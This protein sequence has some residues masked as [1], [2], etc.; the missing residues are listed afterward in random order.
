MRFKSHVK[1]FQAK[2]WVLGILHRGSDKGLSQTASSIMATCEDNFLLFCFFA[3]KIEKKKKFLHLC[4]AVKI[5]CV[6]N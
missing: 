6:G 3:Y 1:I 5:T 2:N 4:N